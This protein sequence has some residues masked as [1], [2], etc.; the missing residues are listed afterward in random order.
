MPTRMGYSLMAVIGLF[1]FFGSVG[2]AAYMESTFGLDPLVGL[3][4]VCPS[5]GF[6]FHHLR[7]WIAVR[8]GIK[9]NKSPFGMILGFSLLIIFQ[10]L[11]P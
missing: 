4:I 8:S 2:I 11:N 6:I 1:F 5:M 10:Y 3:I 7:N 9:T